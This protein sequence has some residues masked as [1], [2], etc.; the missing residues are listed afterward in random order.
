VV[1]HQQ[2]EYTNP[3]TGMEA[4]SQQEPRGL[5]PTSVGN[6]PYYANSGVVSLRYGPI[7]P[8]LRTV[9]KVWVWE[10]AVTVG[11]A[12]GTAVGGTGRLL[13]WGDVLGGAKGGVQGGIARSKIACFGEAL[14][15]FCEL[16]DTAVHNAS[17]Y[18]ILL[19]L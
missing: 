2:S 3:R 15:L 13:A 10:T 16:L 18:P 9:V 6:S 1:S 11:T 5:L 7:G 8:T 14:H 17:P 12:V 4:T 19:Q